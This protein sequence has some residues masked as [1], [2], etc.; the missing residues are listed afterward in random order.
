[1]S[2]S[3]QHIPIQEV[4]DS[5]VERLKIIGFNEVI[6]DDDMDS[7]KDF[8]GI[9]DQIFEDSFSCLQIL[10][11]ELYDNDGERAGIEFHVLFHTQKGRRI[12]RSLSKNDFQR[13]KDFLDKNIFLPGG[14][15]V[16]EYD[17]PDR[18]HSR[19]KS[20]PHLFPDNVPGVEIHIGGWLGANS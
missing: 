13:L 17:P 9:S 3:F 11:Y 19:G 6:F 15:K 7:F 8:F 14:L 2:D 18:D 5:I 1:M 4:S 16:L 20:N 10:L 12:Q